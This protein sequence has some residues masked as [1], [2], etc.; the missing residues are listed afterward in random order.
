MNR[1]T[2]DALVATVGGGTIRAIVLGTVAEIL[3]ERLCSFL[4]QPHDVLPES[5]EL[6]VHRSVFLIPC[7]WQEQRQSLL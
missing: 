3:G 5:L 1:R 2:C 4:L 6:V 7:H